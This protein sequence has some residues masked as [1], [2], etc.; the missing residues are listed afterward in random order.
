MYLKLEFFFSGTIC[1]MFFNQIMFLTPKNLNLTNI[2]KLHNF[3]DIDVKNKG[4]ICV[5]KKM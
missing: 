1:C 2:E 5:P 3:E 4:Y